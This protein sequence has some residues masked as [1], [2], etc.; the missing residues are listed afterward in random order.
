MDDPSASYVFLARK[1]AAAKQQIKAYM[2][3]FT[4]CRD[5]KN[6]SF[7]MQ[8]RNKILLIPNIAFRHWTKHSPHV[9]VKGQCYISR[10]KRCNQIEGLLILGHVT[11]KQETGSNPN[12]KKKDWFASTLTLGMGLNSAIKKLQMPPSCWGTNWKGRNTGIIFTLRCCVKNFNNVEGV[13][14]CHPFCGTISIY[15]HRFWSN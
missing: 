15:L 6:D 12:S 1:T 3:E 13:P 2:L 4:A 11:Q 7:Y 9:L 5:E 10:Q 14:L 8:L